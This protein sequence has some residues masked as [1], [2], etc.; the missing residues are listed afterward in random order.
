MAKILLVIAADQF[1]DEEYA[2]PR[3]VLEGRGA[4]VVTASVAPGPCRGR[5]GLLARADVAL[6]DV[7]PSAYDGIVFVGGA[8]SSCFFDDLDAHHIAREMLDSGKVVGA[9][10]IAPST[11]AHAGLLE[12][13]RVTSFPSQEEDLVAH[14]A[15]Y[16]GRA[17]EI[18]GH[19]ITASGPDAARDFGEA[20]AHLLGI[21]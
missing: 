20:I 11:L 3:E 18:D 9:I 1:R 8:G 16:T 12:G 14:G 13:V 17:I 2:H 15:T 10:C 7:E 21:A 19:I 6:R 4:E 5:F